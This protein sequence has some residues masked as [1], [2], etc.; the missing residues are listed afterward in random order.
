[1]ALC[2]PLRDPP[3]SEGMACSQNDQRRNLRDLI[4]SFFFREKK[5]V[6]GKGNRSLLQ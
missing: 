6:T 5:V 4:V 1:M 2:E 3:E